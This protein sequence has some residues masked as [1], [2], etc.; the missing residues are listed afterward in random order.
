[1]SLAQS[2]PMESVL[3]GVTF[4]RGRVTGKVPGFTQ[5]HSANLKTL[6]VPCQRQGRREEGICWGKGSVEEEENGS[7]HRQNTL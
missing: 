2:G 3:W 7:K 5:A 1:M 6:S 4:F